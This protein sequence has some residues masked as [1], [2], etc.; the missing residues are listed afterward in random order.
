[1]FD[2]KK[3][4]K[5][6]SKPVPREHMSE[7]VGAGNKTLHYVAGD[8]VIHTLNSLFGPYNVSS[9]IDEVRQIVNR[10]E[11]KTVKRPPKKT[12]NGYEDQ[13][14]EQVAWLEVQYMVTGRLVIQVGDRTITKCGIGTGKGSGWAS[15]DK[16]IAQIHEVAVKGAETDMIKR[17]AK[18]L[19]PVFGLSI[20]E[21]GK[22]LYASTAEDETLPEEDVAPAGEKPVVASGLTPE[23]KA[24]GGKPTETVADGAKAPETTKTAPTVAA[25]Q[26]AEASKPP[27]KPVEQKQVEQ[28]P[29]EQKPVEQKPATVAE[30]AGKPAA[31]TGAGNTATPAQPAAKAASA[32]AQDG[33]QTA[34][35]AGN[36]T[37]RPTDVT[38]N[39]VNPRP[40]PPAQDIKDGIRLPPFD[41][42]ALEALDS[43][44]WVQKMRDLK[45]I[46]LETKSSEEIISIAKYTGH[47]ERLINGNPRIDSGFKEQ[48]HSLM[49]DYIRAH[50][51]KLNIQVDF[52]KYIVDARDGKAEKED[53]TAPF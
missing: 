44:G 2:E 23:A 33:S 6:L 20:G 24:T 45:K 9:H 12:A 31:V 8:Y 16:T 10:T 29:V 36:A 32:G 39:P 17:A 35:V 38:L 51:A 1:M 3:L 5:D 15:P 52:E 7:R 53:F 27:Q 4:I 34:M 49:G 50:L 13:G 43:S 11:N 21:D 18:K 42:A 22:Q 28:K 48:V 40:A 41:E 14:S 30:T 37:P 47:C 19:G 26:T 46:L 25:Q